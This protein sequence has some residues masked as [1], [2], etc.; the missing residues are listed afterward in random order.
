MSDRA[1]AL[2]TLPVVELS[3]IA[4]DAMLRDGVSLSVIKRFTEWDKGEPVRSIEREVR[5]HVPGW[6]SAILACE[7]RG[8]MRPGGLCRS[9]PGLPDMRLY[10]W[11]DGQIPRFQRA[12]GLTDMDVP[13][14]LAQR[15]AGGAPFHLSN[16]PS[17]IQAMSR[18]ERWIRS[19]SMGV[20]PE[21]RLCLCERVYL[22]LV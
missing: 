8:F 9:E 7:Q 10:W 18:Y 15:F 13:G 6:H 17:E 19:V 5:H 11:V 12:R 14:M 2:E 4:G 21:E 20:D 1:D 3:L 22:R 16:S